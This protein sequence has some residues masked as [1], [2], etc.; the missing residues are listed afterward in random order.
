MRT[1]IHP[2]VLRILAFYEWDPGYYYLVF[3]R[4]YG[5][6]LFRR[7]EKKVRVVPCAACGVCRCDVR[8]CVCVSVCLDLS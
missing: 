2:N 5:G 3:E 1:L 7:T 4:M 6:E 8:W